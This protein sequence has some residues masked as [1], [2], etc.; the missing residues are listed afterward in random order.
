VGDSLLPLLDP[1]GRALLEDRWR[2]FA[3][4]IEWYDRVLGKRVADA[5]RTHGRPFAVRVV[6][7]LPSTGSARLRG[8]HGEHAV[9]ER[10]RPSCT[11]E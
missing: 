6:R 5:D 7:R 11:I 3:A 9:R 10:A 8:R 1:K 4:A 2:A